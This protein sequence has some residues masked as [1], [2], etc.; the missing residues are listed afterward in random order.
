MSYSSWPQIAMNKPDESTH[1]T[2]LCALGMLISRNPVYI[3]YRLTLYLHQHCISNILSFPW[4]PQSRHSPRRGKE[5][6]K[7]TCHHP[8]LTNWFVNTFWLVGPILCLWQYVEDTVYHA[9]VHWWITAKRYLSM[10]F[11]ISSI[12]FY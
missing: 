7:W 9:V 11:R 1:T 2:M 8:K 12:P 6:N 3:E 10:R 5:M 4:G